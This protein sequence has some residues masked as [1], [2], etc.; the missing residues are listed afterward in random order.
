MSTERKFRV[1]TY[2]T[3]TEYQKIQTIA[4]ENNCSISE[5]IYDLL[6]HQSLKKLTTIS[7]YEQRFRE[8]HLR[9]GEINRQ[10]L[11]IEGQEAKTKE[12]IAQIISLVAE[13]SEMIRSLK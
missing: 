4:R 1:S 3:D 13:I 12:A 7:S 9:L 5:I 2:L 6:Q 10:L 8:Y 11:S